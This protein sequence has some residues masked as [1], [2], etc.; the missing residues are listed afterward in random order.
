LA[1]FGSVE[2]LRKASVEEIASVAGISEKLAESIVR[3]LSR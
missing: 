1:K 3:F 2:R